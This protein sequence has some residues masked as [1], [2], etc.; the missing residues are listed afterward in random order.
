MQADVMLIEAGEVDCTGQGL[1]FITGRAATGGAIQQP[2]LHSLRDLAG[3]SRQCV[4][5]VPDP[6]MVISRS[7]DWGRVTRL[8]CYMALTNDGYAIATL[9]VLVSVVSV[10]SGS[11]GRDVQPWDTPK[12]IETE[13]T[14]NTRL[15]SA[16]AE[17]NTIIAVK[18]D[19]MCLY[20]NSVWRF[21]TARVI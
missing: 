14:H 1:S 19:R 6:L 12:L 4:A 2:Q 21:I 20:K 15:S 13:H 8:S 9:V 5:L 10:F 3:R 16:F 11:A 18:S 17:V 7:S